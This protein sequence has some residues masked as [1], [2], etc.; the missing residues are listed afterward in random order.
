MKE[1]L[2]LS[3]P[4]S[5]FRI[6]PII[7]LF[8][9]LRVVLV[10]LL[11]AASA[12]PLSFVRPSVAYAQQPTD[13]GYYYTVQPGDSWGLL[14]NISGLSVSELQ[15][16]NPDSMRFNQWLRVGER[17]LIPAPLPENARTQSTVHVVQPGESWG[18]IA[19]QYDLT[20]RLLKSANGDSI[21]RNDVLYVGEELTIPG[22]FQPAE[23]SP[24]TPVTAASAAP[25]QPQVHEVKRGDSWSIIAA[26]YDVTIRELK[27]A[28]PGAVRVRDILYLGEKLSIPTASASTTASSTTDETAPA[29]E[30]STG[31]VVAEVEPDTVAQSPSSS[32]SSSQTTEPQT[33]SQAAED[34]SGS[35]DAQ[36]ETPAAVDED[37]ATEAATATDEDSSATEQAETEAA[38]ETSD[39]ASAEES[40]PAP[41][42][43]AASSADAAADEAVGAELTNACPEMFSD[44]VAFLEDSLSAAEADLD[45]VL[46]QVESCE[47]LKQSETADW[48][49]DNLDDLLIIL[50]AVNP[51]FKSPEGDLFIFSGLEDGS[52][53]LGYHARSAGQVNLLSKEDINADNLPDIT[54]SDTTCGASTCFATVNVRSWS[55]NEWRDWTDGTLTMAHPEIALEDTSD[56][57]QSLEILLSGGIY[58][59]LGAGP[60]RD[61]VEVWGSVDGAP[62]TLLNLTHGE[63][64]CIYFFVIDGNAALL[65][66]DVDG[67]AAAESFYTQAA[68]DPD[69]NAC[70]TRENE[71]EELRSFSLFRLALVAAYRGDAEEAANKIETLSSDYPDSVYDALGRIWLDVYTESG[72][73]AT[74]CTAATLFAEENPEAWRMLADFGYINPTFSAEEVCPL[75][76]IELSTVTDADSTAE[77]SGA[78]DDSGSEAPA[79]SASSSATEGAETDS[80]AGAGG[81]GEDADEGSGAETADAD[82]GAGSPDENTAT[83]SSSDGNSTSNEDATEDDSATQNEEADGATSA[84]VAALP[85]CAT[86]L[87]D[88]STKAEEAINAAKGDAAAIEDWLR[89]CKMVT[90]ENGAMLNE[91]LNGDGTA[92]YVLFPTLA[93]EGGYG[94]GGTQ[95]LVLIYHAVDES[96]A[97]YELTASPDV[98]GKPMPLGVEDYNEDG[99]TDLAF[100]VE[101]CS[102]FCVTEVQLLSWNGDVYTVYITPGATIAEGE[103]KFAL[104]GEDDPGTGKAIHLVGGV[105]GT[106]E[107]G[108]NVPHEEIWQSINGRPY[109]RISWIY[110]RSV[111]GSNCLG[112]RLVEADMALQAAPALGYAEAVQKYAAAIDPA[113]QAC[114]IQGIP[115]AD[116]LILLQGLASFRLIQAQALSGDLGDA[117]T[118]LDALSRGQ[119]DSVY[120]SIAKQWLEQY[121]NSGD[122]ALACEAVRPIIEENAEVWQI[123]DHYGYNHPALAAQQICFAP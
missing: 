76:D 115:A 111:E 46:A 34:G 58:G 78:A 8:P 43:D 121:N 104:V 122:A 17:I 96:G 7:R 64:T 11:L 5:L 26:A 48:T 71:E 29:T 49:A 57:G 13:A 14:A 33:G 47:V 72:D 68:T 105:S 45:A 21:R 56:E 24:A 98:F 117:N 95:G 52:Y 23:S 31:E 97:E 51:D 22:I 66:A 99:Q 89:S 85:D 84:E 10:A 55:E 36:S 42:E 54:W 110:D 63:S 83:N 116:E 1:M 32:P 73:V 106:P 6:D 70:W 25:S 119:P 100:T 9:Q 50:E 114:S 28:N 4:F 41:A 27:E 38:V 2:M 81:E 20:V 103:V 65:Q 79:D 74:A 3:L 69:L 30:P 44:Y 19:A 101:G 35:T 86:D 77:A 108:L 87:S 90:D 118:T 61:R 15:E 39:A 94:P 92:D 91:D 82:A 107:G 59:S 113:L 109:Q 53:E 40:R 120:T 75:L 62:Y 16:A 93:V 123:T 60:Q 12:L 18:A 88:F 37:P 102:S 80:A 112:L 67:L